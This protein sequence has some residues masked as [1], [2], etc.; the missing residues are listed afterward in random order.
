MNKIIGR[1]HEISELRRFEKSGKPEFIALFGRRRVGKTFLIQQLYSNDFS[2]YVT[3]SI[4][5]NKKDQLQYFCTALEEYGYNGTI[6][7]D[8]D[9]AFLCLKKLLSD[10]QG[11]SRMIVFIDELPC[12]DTP[13]SGFVKSLSHFWNSWGANQ[14]RIMLIVCGSA[15]SWMVKNI[16][17]NR[18]GLHNRT[19]HEIHLAP[20]TL[21][22]CEEYLC[23]NG[24]YWDR[25]TIAQTYMIL[26]GIPYYLSI[27]NP[28]LSLAQNIDRLLFNENGELRREY[29]R[30]FRSLF[31]KPEPYMKVIEGLAS[32]R[33]GMTRAELISQVGDISTGRMSE[34]LEDLRHCD[35]IRYYKI[36]RKKINLNEGLYQ[37]TDF[38]TI[39]YLT[40]CKEKTTNPHFWSDNLLSSKFSNWYGLAY[41]RLCLAH[42]PQIKGALGIDRI[43]TEYYAWYSDAESP[44]CQIDLLIER[45]DRLINLCEIKY[46]S[47]YYVLKKEEMDKILRRITLF[48]A[49]TECKYPIVPTL[50]TTF[51]LAP[52]K[53]SSSL[54]NVITL[55][56]LFQP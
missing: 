34:I 18:G 42:I 33:K 39:F 13:R 7:K 40:F 20:F 6:P 35:F 50:I 17:D 21:K 54:H 24:I 47:E 1:Q 36:R 22:E 56:A 41:E 15:T 28:Q 11:D 51:G 23:V 4:D 53:Y 55:D 29:A 45:A 46:S 2:F 32:N 27:L 44:R 9:E 12:F 5:G 16:L 19:T 26:G 48:K 38:F 14:P 52:N 43:Q 8:W 3:G 37:L 49:S 31:R 10:K 25:L 30:L